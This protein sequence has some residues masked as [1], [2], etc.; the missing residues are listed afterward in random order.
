MPTF[1]HL[2]KIF[3]NNAEIILI[4]L[5]EDLLLNKSKHL[6]SEETYLKLTTTKFKIKNGYIIPKYTLQRSSVKES[7]MQLK[8]LGQILF[9]LVVNMENKLCL[10]Q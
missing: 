3:F 10:L 4:Y 7:K 6:I 5:Q 1:I 9:V 8:L 2:C